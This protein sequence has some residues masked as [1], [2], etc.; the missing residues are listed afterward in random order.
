[1]KNLF[2]HIT[3][4]LALILLGVGC[5]MYPFWL[6]NGMLDNWYLIIAVFIASYVGFIA[7]LIHYLKFLK[8][9]ECI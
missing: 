7:N 4:I 2:T 8:D 6:M 5:V 3:S 9:N 1:M